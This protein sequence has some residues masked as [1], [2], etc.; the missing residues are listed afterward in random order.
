[1]TLP[2]LAVKGEWFVDPFFFFFCFLVLCTVCSS[3]KFQV[4][5]GLFALWLF[6]LLIMYLCLLILVLMLNFCRTQWYVFPFVT[7][8]CE[9]NFVVHVCSYHVNYT[10]T[11]THI[12]FIESGYLS[13]IGKQWNSFSYLWHEEIFPF[14]FMCDITLI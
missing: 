11:H 2:W 4:K 8:L 5:H 7:M 13:I 12:H 6:W 1:M 14:S 10:H 9:Q 3:W